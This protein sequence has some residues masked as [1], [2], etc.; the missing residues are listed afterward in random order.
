MARKIGVLIAMFLIYGC[1]HKTPLDPT[2]STQATLNIRIE[3]QSNAVGLIGKGVQ[4]LQDALNRPV[5]I[6]NCGVNGTYIREHMPGTTIYDSC[7]Q[8]MADPDV[9][10]WYQGE[11]DAAD[12]GDYATWAE[13]FTTLV[14]EW[15]KINPNV[16]VV[17]AEL[18]TTTWGAL[19][20]HWED[21]KAQQRAISLPNMKMI[22]T[23]DLSLVDG[24]HLTP[25]SYYVAGQRFG[26]AIR[27][28]KA[29]E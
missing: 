27:Q 21:V 7:K 18:A 8:Q 2:V 4:G 24:L 1:K 25:D 20:G 29:G 6:I 16:I 28:L 23:S 11:S 15:R 14:R 13:K 5:R 10:V 3:G 12:D 17:Y 26:D 9:I 19:T 22:K